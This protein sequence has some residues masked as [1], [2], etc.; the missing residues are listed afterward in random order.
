MGLIS[1]GTTI[2]DAGSLASGLVVL[3]LSLKRLLLV[4]LAFNFVDGS[5][6]V[7]LDNTYKEYLFTFKNIQ[8]DETW[9]SNFQ[10]YIQ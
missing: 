4:L 5:S 3:L 8:P 9:I 10:F 6:G 7:V 1:N 2:F